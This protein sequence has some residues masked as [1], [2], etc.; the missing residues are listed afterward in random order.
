MVLNS[1]SD[2]KSGEGFQ[3][4]IGKGKVCCFDTHSSPWSMYRLPNLGRVRFGGGVASM[5][6]SAASYLIVGIRSEICQK[7][8]FRLY[9]G[10]IECLT[11]KQSRE[12][13]WLVVI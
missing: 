4:I 2:P 1:L 8:T 7:P 11:L 3:D 13:L 9:S 5:V 10:Q 12:F 6:F